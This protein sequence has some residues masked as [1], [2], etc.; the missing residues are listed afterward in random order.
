MS[1][2]LWWNILAA[3]EVLVFW[4]EWS[5]YK[6]KTIRNTAVKFIWNAKTEQERIDLVYSIPYWWRKDLKK[7]ISTILMGLPKDWT[8]L[9]EQEIESLF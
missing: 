9:N 1:D 5:N 2:W 7:E 3:L 6:W 8:E 4:M